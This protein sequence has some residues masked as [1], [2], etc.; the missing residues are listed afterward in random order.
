MSNDKKVLLRISNLKQWFPLKKR[1]MY[2]K[3]NDGIDLEIY[4]GE[5]FGLVGESG[6]GK[7]TFGRTILQVYPQTD[8]RTMYYGRTID[9]LCPEYIRETIKTLDKRRKH[10]AQLE[11]KR[12]HLQAEYDAMS[13]EDKLKRKRRSLPSTKYW[14]RCVNPIRTTS[15]SRSTRGIVMTVLILH[16]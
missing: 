7:S 1:G 5:T 4:E 14:I 9:E 8:G 12:D 3:A 10:L 13:D 16:A 6:C 15:A 11:E 2:V